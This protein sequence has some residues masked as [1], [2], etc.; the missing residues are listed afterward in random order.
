MENENMKMDV[1]TVKDV[2]IVDWSGKITLGEETMAFRQTVR[3]LV[4]HGA[5]KIVINLRDVVY[6]DSS[7]VGELVSTYATV[8][9]NGGQLKLLKL[10]NKIHELLTLT[11]LLTVF[12]V[13][14]NEQDALASFE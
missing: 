5:K 3:D 14:D 13:F 2:R 6:I 9:N 8:T 4:K 10:S 12:E 1:R 11:K 7:G